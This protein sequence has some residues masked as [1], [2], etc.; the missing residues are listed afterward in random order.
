[1]RA[2]IPGVLPYLA[3]VVLRQTLQAMRHV[4]AI[5]VAIVVANVVNVG[6]NWVLIFGASACPPSAWWGA[7]GRRRSGAG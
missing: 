6:L 2:S 1:V 5:V 3:F 4:R 7:R